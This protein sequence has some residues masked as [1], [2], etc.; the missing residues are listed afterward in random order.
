LEAFLDF[1]GIMLLEFNPAIHY[2]PVRNWED[3][4]QV[5]QAH[6]CACGLY[7]I[8]YRNEVASSSDSDVDR[9][10]NI[11]NVLDSVLLLSIRRWKIQ[12]YLQRTFL[13]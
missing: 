4:W 2:V 7:S 10:V 9:Y 12:T 11:K 6:L 13:P 3:C 8:Y 1:H 5:L